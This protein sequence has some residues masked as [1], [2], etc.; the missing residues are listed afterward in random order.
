[1]VLILISNTILAQEIFIIDD[2]KNR[3]IPTDF[4][5]YYEGDIKGNE[6]LEIDDSSWNKKLKRHIENSYHKAD[7]N[8]F[9]PNIRNTLISRLRYLDEA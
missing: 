2:G 3:K 9:W 4:Y 7:Y 5:L 8:L 1:M 6:V